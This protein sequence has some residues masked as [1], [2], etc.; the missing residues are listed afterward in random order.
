ML[1]VSLI[2]AAFL[3]ALYGA[4]SGAIVALLG[5]AKS[6]TVESFDPSKAMQ[7]II[8]GAAVGVL[9]IQLNM[10]YEDAY[11]WAASMGVITIIEY[12]K[13]MES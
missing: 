1:D 10:R 2:A 5:Y 9:G 7:T 12:V 8:V 11:Q 3:N 6:A 4:I 13:K